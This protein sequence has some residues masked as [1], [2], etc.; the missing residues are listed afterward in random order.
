MR[1]QNIFRITFQ[2][3]QLERYYR[4][5][6]SQKQIYHYG[7]Y[8]CSMKA[9]KSTGWHSAFWTTQ[10]FINSAESSTTMNEI[11]ILES[12]SN[13]QVNGST[14]HI[15]LHQWTPRHITPNAYQSSYTKDCEGTVMPNFS[16]GFNTFGALVDEEKVTYYFN[17]KRIAELYY[18]GLFP[19]YTVNPAEILMTC[20]AHRDNISL[21]GL[22]QDTCEFEYV[23]YYKKVN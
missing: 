1:A 20:L 13:G 22:P 14:H 3:T 10:D 16:L 17:R 4:G 8:E 21:D 5:I 15:A 23:R 12:D 9:P 11:D 6:I 2:L 7:Y 18:Q 19:N